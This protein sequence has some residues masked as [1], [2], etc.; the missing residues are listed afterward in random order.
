MIK[1]HIKMKQ[2]GIKGRG[3]FAFKRF[4]KGEVI[5]ISPYIL[6]PAK[7]YSRVKN[8]RLTYY[9]FGVR[10]K[11]CAI[12]LGYTSIYNHMENPNA[13]FVILKRSAKIKIVAT[14]DIAKGEEICTNYGYDPTSY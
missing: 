11:T 6:V 8:T 10:G 3:I 5:E 9:W 14:K 7:D 13:T 1:L 12:G 2:A 4:K